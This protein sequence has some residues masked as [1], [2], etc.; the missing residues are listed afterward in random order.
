MQTLVNLLF[1]H[2]LSINIMYVQKMNRGE[3]AKY[4]LL[5][6]QINIQ[7]SELQRLAPGPRQGFVA[8]F[9]GLQVLLDSTN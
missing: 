2:F 1:N 4:A 7:R 5:E 9:S 3:K 8:E 6:P